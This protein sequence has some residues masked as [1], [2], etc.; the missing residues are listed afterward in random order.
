MA[1]EVLSQNEI[2]SL[3]SSISSGEMDAEELKQE[4]KEQKVRV[5]DLS[6]HCGFQRIKS[7]A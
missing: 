1:D 4:E 7:A 6:G 3:L 5:Y 2:D